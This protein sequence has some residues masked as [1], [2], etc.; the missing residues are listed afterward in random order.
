MLNFNIKPVSTDLYKAL[1]E[2]INL[3]T[4]PLG[5]LGKLEELALKIGCIQNTLTP[6]LKKPVMLVFAGDHGIAKEGVSLYPQ[7]VTY[8]MVLNFLNKGAGINVFTK[9]NNID[10][11]IIDAGVA[12]DFEPHPDLINAKI[13]KGAGNFLIEPAMTK[14]QC[15]EA[16][17]KGAEIAEAV[18]KEGCNIIGF[19]EMG[20]GN[21]SSATVLLSLL[22]DTPVKECVGRGTGLDDEKIRIKKEILQ[23]A[24]DNNPVDSSPISVL[25]TF[26]GFEI[27]M[28]AGAM[29]KSAELGMILMIDG[30]ITSS[31][32]LVATKI[33][34]TILEY[35]IFAHKSNERGHKL[36]LEYL[37]ADPILDLG[38]RLGEGTGVAVA[39]PIIQSAVEFL[40]K[41]AS[42]ESANVSNSVVKS[43]CKI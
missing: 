32:L 16:I 17:A 37:E 4:K 8:Q 30:F 5:S 15:I 26:G 11:K 33:C 1:Q 20:I 39:Y 6:E 42:F 31:A 18:C 24:I 12:F 9:Q 13:A 23:K 35:C 43:E 41:M 38:M 27:A 10:I 36:M 7:E 25:A 40:N 22:C 3:K 21:T 14:D 29:L 2:K 34:P 28:M 19:G